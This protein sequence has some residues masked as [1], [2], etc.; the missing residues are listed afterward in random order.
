MKYPIGIQNFDHIIE[1]DYVYVDKTD[2]I[3]SLVKD[4]D[5]CF[6]CYPHSFG[7]SLLVSILKNYYLGRKELY[8]GLKIDGLE[9][10]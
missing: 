5:I 4:G 7:K 3:Y 10:D 1:D 8:K 9:K 2:I 6:L